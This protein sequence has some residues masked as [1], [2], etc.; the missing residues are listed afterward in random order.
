MLIPNTHLYKNTILHFK[1][2]NLK[3]IPPS[4]IASKPKQEAMRQLFCYFIVLKFTPV[5]EVN[6]IVF[7]WPLLT[8]RVDNKQN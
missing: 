1:N 2:S 3:H 8:I 5:I 7:S 6:L 4:S